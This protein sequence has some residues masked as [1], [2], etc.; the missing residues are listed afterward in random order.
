M[1]VMSACA[2]LI[3]ELRAIQGSVLDLAE[4]NMAVVVPGYT[5][6]QRAQPL[7][8][9]H[10]L[11]AYFEMFE[12]DI[13]RFAA[14]F[15]RADV[16][17]LGSGAIAGVP[18]PID[19]AFVARML[20]F[21]RISENSVDAVSDRD[22]IVDFHAAAAMT[23]MHVSRLCEE[24]VLWSSEEFGF[25]KLPAEF[26]TGSSMMPQKRNADIAELARARTGRVYGNLVASLTMLKGLPLSY[27]RDLQEDKP[28][29]LESIPLTAMAV[30]VV[31]AMLAKL[32]FDGERTAAAASG[33]G[34]V[35][36]TDV[37]D[38]LVKKGVPFR[39]AHQAVAELVRY[40]E[41][42]SKALADLTLDE[43]R[44][45]APAFDEDILGLDVSASI[46]ARDVPG[47]TAPRR[48]RAALKKAR[49]RMSA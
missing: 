7:L 45:F 28:A 33:G 3:D 21:S 16:L 47:G 13:D 6:L 36:A 44:R 15:E 22:F 30:E 29:L 37:A 41:G 49:K 25:V 35:L 23:M 46:A 40:A 19:R 17:P 31:S 4:R 2:S 11:L 34:Y 42:E 20:G 24:I 10:Q 8:L 5:H 12:R 9:A 39:D 26:A 43:Y 18:Y 1:L 27:N 48:V 32:E 14:C 38:Y